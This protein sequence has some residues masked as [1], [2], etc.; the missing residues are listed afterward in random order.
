MKKTVL[1]ILSMF[2]VF[3]LASCVNDMT[4]TSSGSSNST[5]SSMSNN[6]TSSLVNE[7]ILEGEYKEMS[8]GSE[9]VTKVRVEVENGV[10]KKVT[11]AEGSNPYTTSDI[12]KEN[13]YWTQKED[14]AL[15]SYVGKRVDEIKSS[16]SLPVDNIAGATLT[17]NRLYQAIKDALNK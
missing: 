3:F 5:Y 9:Y 4:S 17:S 1:I 2:F 13:T 7:N 16:T 15:S 12:W 14:K 11:I 8:F 10:I 6:T